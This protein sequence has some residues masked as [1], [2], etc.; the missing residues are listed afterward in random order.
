MRCMMLICSRMSRVTQPEVNYKP[1]RPEGKGNRLI[2]VLAL[3]RR[4]D[5]DKSLLLSNLLDADPMEER[6]ESDA[7]SLPTPASLSMLQGATDF[8][9]ENSILTNVQGD[10]TVFKFGDGK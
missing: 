7:T 3:Y 1:H 8:K 9:I 2:Q 10:F 6:A 5:T 4:Q